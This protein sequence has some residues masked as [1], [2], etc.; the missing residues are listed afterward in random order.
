[1]KIRNAFSLNPLG[2]GA[3]DTIVV[4]FAANIVG[5]AAVNQGNAGRGRAM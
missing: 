2:H 4:A 5:G 3:L 1:M